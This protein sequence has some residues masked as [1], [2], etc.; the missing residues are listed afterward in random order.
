MARQEHTPEDI[1]RI[2]GEL[3]AVCD[4]LRVI[5]DSM[6]K[7]GAPHVL[8]QSA[9]QLNKHIPEVVRWSEKSEVDARD[10]VRAYLAGVDSP[11]EIRRR[12]NAAQ[13]LKSA[14]KKAP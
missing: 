3:T 1:D 8:L 14:K 7:S 13:K 4:R 12:L 10:Q 6:R 5:A 11:V 2:I 9:S